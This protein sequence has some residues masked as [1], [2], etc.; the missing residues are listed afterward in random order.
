MLQIINKLKQTNQKETKELEEKSLL[1]HP[2]GINFPLLPNIEKFTAIR[3]VPFSRSC[4][5][6]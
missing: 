4:R 3:T 1:L 6:F 5:D 2:S